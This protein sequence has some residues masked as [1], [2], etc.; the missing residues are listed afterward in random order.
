MTMKTTRLPTMPKQ[1]PL[2]AVAVVVVAAAAAVAWPVGCW[3]CQEH[4]RM[5]RKASVWLQ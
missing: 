1:S 4:P 5:R 2:V 3:A